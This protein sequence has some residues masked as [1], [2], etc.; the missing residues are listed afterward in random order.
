MTAKDAELPKRR[1]AM[2]QRLWPGRHDEQVLRLF[3]A[4]KEWEIHVQL[5]GMLKLY[6]DQ[7]KKL[8]KFG[9]ANPAKDW[10]QCSRDW[11]RL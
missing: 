2:V 9:Q 8:S 6:H 5:E 7:L 10:P 1:L 4:L 11:S 3:E